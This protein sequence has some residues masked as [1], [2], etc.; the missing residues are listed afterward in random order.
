MEI[1]N[2]ELDH[3]KEIN[4]KLGKDERRNVISEGGL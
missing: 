3:K 2:L 1:K 4:E